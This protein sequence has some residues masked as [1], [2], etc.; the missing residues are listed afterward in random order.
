MTDS[1]TTST[2]FLQPDDETLT[3]RIDLA[4]STVSA[5]VQELINKCAVDEQ[6]IRSLTVG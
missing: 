6:E 4:E 3:K 5:R 2:Q 1:G